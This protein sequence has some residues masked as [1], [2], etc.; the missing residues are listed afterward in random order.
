M[1]IIIEINRVAEKIDGIAKA[2]EMDFRTKKVVETEIY[3]HLLLFP[4]PIQQLLVQEY[5][6]MEDRLSEGKQM[7]HIGGNSISC[8]CKFYLRYQLPCQ[9]ILHSDYSWETYARNFEGDMG[10]GIY[11]DEAEIEV[12]SEEKEQGSL[13]LANRKLKIKE[14]YHH[15]ST[16]FFELEEALGNEEENVRSTCMERWLD[17]LRRA[18]D[19]FIKFSVPDLLLG[20]SIMVNDSCVL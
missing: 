16:R 11:E 4:L 15:L 10:L 5:N 9:H 18:N 17:G 6:K 7:A 12:M 19:P 20:D 13:S 14:I 3:P 8:H 1:G 2:A